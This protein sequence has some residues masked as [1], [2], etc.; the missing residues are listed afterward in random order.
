M[1][2]AGSWS[3]I[4][5]AVCP[6]GRI[7]HLLQGFPSSPRSHP[8]IVSD[9]RAGS[10]RSL[11]LCQVILEVLSLAA[12]EIILDPGPGLIQSSFPG[13]KDSGSLV[14]RDRPVLPERVCSTISVHH[15]THSLC[16]SVH[17]RER[18]PSF[19]RPEC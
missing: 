11:A 18:F 8:D 13:G 17:L 1:A 19:R 9:I 5:G 4:L 2:L 6:E 16:A 7:P 3:R 14:S 15:S 10:P 12:L